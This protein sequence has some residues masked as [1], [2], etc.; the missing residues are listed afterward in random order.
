MIEDLIVRGTKKRGEV[1]LRRIDAGTNAVSWQS[2]FPAVPKRTR[3]RLLETE[4]GR[5]RLREVWRKKMKMEVK[6][7]TTTTKIAA[8]QRIA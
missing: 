5:R 7:T 4:R 3:L 2:A 1:R 8:A 6:S